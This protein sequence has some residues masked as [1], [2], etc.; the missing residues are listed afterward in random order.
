M[1]S[2]DGLIENVGQCAALR[3]FCLIVAILRHGIWYVQVE[4]LVICPRS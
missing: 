3:N 1:I 4:E 2:H